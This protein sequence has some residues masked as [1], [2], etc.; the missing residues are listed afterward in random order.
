MTWFSSG[1][2][3]P[4]VFTQTLDDVDA[5]LDQFM[6][7]LYDLVQDMLEGDTIRNMLRGMTKRELK[8]MPPFPFPREFFPRGTFPEGMRFS[9]GALPGVPPSVLRA[10]DSPAEAAKLGDLYVAAEAKAKKHGGRASEPLA[11]GERRRFAGFKPFGEGPARPTAPRGVKGRGAGR[12]GASTRGGR[13]GGLGFDAETMTLLNRLSRTVPDKVFTAA[14][15]G[16]FRAL[17]ALIDAVEAQGMVGDLDAL[18]RIL[19]VDTEGEGGEEESA[20]DSSGEERPDP[21][22]ARASASAASPP[23]PVTP[24]QASSATPSAPAPVRALMD[25]AKDGSVEALAALLDRHPALLNA[26]APGLGNT[27]AH[28]TCARGHVDA[29]VALCRRGADMEAANAEGGN[30]F[31]AACG[32]GQAGTTVALLQVLSINSVRTLLAQRNADG[33]TPRELAEARK[34]PEVLAALDTWTAE[35]LEEAATLPPASFLPR[36]PKPMRESPKLAEA[37]CVDESEA[38]EPTAPVVAASKVPADEAPHPP[39][40]PEASGEGSAASSAHRTEPDLSSAADPDPQALPP[41]EL[42]LQWLDA[43][44]AGDLPTLQALHRSHPAL[45]LIGFRG[46]GTRYALV[47]HSALHWCAAKGFAEAAR[48][49]VAQGADPSARNAVGNTPLHSAVA[50]DSPSMINLLVTAAGADPSVLNELGESVTSQAPGS[51][52]QGQD[53]M[54]ALLDVLRA[55]WPLQQALRDGAKPPVKQ[56]LELLGCVQRRREAIPALRLVPALPSL[57]G[58]DRVELGALCD[59]VTRALEV[60]EPIQVLVSPPDRTHGPARDA[61]SMGG[62]QEEASEDTASASSENSSSSAA[63]EAARLRGNDAF[64][65]KDYRAAIKLYSMSIRLDR[66]QAVLFS[67]RA[68]CYTALGEWENAVED[69]QMAIRLKPTWGKAY[70]RLGEAQAGQGIYAE[71]LKT[72]RRGMAADPACPSCAKGSEDMTAKIRSFG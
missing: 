48:W 14:L 17:D 21:G 59:S 2:P 55:I 49:L 54:S 3:P 43:A 16:D 56:M 32:N 66:T 19:G 36:E 24:Q 18:L 30:L 40:A 46:Q 4:L 62:R 63:V 72:F 33:R 51:D 1:C 23:P 70:A 37:A 71:A 41:K 10:L 67:N 26:R 22:D 31:H 8:E 60:P 12:G 47:G 7:T 25:A 52:A 35:N 57:A 45:D 42:G 69:A 11:E 58:L 6:D 61:A 53:R 27:A 34:A 50:N 5:P 20:S 39:R 15:S 13:G 68:A 65:R 64:R 44:R 29:L 9:P 28:W 38:T